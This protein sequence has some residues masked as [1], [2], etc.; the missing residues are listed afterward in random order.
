MV[1]NGYKELQRVTRGYKGLEVV[2]R[3]YSG[4]RELQFE[5]IIKRVFFCK[6]KR[7]E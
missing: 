1:T 7:K 4:Y 5:N 2:T 6:I 3:G